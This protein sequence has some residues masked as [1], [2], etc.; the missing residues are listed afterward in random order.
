M[1]AKAYSA[2]L[3]TGLSALLQW[4]A[5]VLTA[6]SRLERRGLEATMRGL[7]RAG[8][9]SGWVAHAVVLLVFARIEPAVIV[10]MAAAAVLGTAASQFAKRL[11]RRSRPAASI[12]GFTARS[13]VPDPFSFPSGHSTVAFSVATAAVACDPRLGGAETLLATAIAFSRVYL[14]AHYPVDVI[15]GLS[16]GFVCGLASWALLG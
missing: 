4:D 1:S 14:G 11:F 6:V 8:D 7:T 16:L 12:V 3:Q 13:A 2:T 10:V 9:P 15:G 5:A